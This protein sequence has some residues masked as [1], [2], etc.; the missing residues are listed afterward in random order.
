MNIWPEEMCCQE[1]KNEYK[2]I[3]LIMILKQP[4]WPFGELWLCHKCFN[5]LCDSLEKS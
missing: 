4:K 5:K 1:C 2:L 3:N